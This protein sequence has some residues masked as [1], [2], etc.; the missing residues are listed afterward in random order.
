[1]PPQGAV[2]EK[3]K[4]W[5]HA[6]GKTGRELENLAAKKRGRQNKTEGG[7]NNKNNKEIKREPP[8]TTGDCGRKDSFFGPCG[9]Y[10]NSRWGEERSLTVGQ[11]RGAEEKR[12]VP[13][14]TSKQRL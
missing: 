6:V 14:R 3:P 5:G 12:R 11:R 4:K 8:M 2:H 1:V 10:K 7:N 13:M 9:R